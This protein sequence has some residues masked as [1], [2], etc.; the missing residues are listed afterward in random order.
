MIPHFFSRLYRHRTWRV[1]MVYFL[2]LNFLL[3]CRSSEVL[4]PAVFDCAFDLNDASALHPKKDLFQ[5]F[6]DQKV[7]QGVPGIILSVHN[8]AEVEWLGAA[9][10]ADLYNQIPLKP[11]NL[12]RVGSTVKTFTAVVVLMLYEQGLLSLDDPVQKYLPVTLLEKLDNGREVTVR[13][14]LNHS[15]G[16]YNYIQNLQFQTAS[17]NDLTKEWSPGDLLSYAYDKKAYFAPGA[18]VRYSN[19]NYILLGMV[20]ESLTHKPF[21]QV[22]EEKLFQPLHL[23]NTFFA[24]RN[25]VP[26]SIIRGYID[27]YNN[28]D[29][30]ESTYFSGWDYYT[31][32]GGLL[33]NP[34]DLSIFLHALFG[35]RLLKVA[36]LQEAMQW[37][38]PLE[39]E[40]DAYRTAFG[41]GFFKVET[42][43][44]EAYI[45]GGDAI[46]YYAQMMYFPRQKTT[47]VYAT[48]GNYG[49][50]DAL[51]S[52]KDA[53]N[54]L[55]KTVFEMVR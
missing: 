7:R 25:P 14:L 31:A 26:R 22:F 44:G 33:S 1:G 43:Y 52:S 35:G 23:T 34:H 3:G 16:L 13:Q 10:K 42:P 2:L 37:K 39:Q 38:E 29:V 18:D 55:L 40:T 50:I 32:D 20:I 12:T 27:L 15:S 17:L 51:V 41:L 47:V 28:L 46:G 21:Y 53:V 5:A 30:V 6:L 36:T 49:R 45:H 4:A 48:N 9:G 24:A 11:C 54:N 8:Q 19:T